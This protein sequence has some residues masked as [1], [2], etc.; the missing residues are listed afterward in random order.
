VHGKSFQSALSGH[1][2]SFILEEGSMHC[3][4]CGAKVADG[5]SF[6]GS[7]GQP[8]VGYSVATTTAAPYAGSALG[9]TPAGVRAYAGFWLR[10]VAYLID[11]LVAMFVVAIVAALAIGFLG[12]EFFRAQIEEMGRG[13]NGPN[14]VFPVMLVV[15]IATF[16]AFLLIV[17]WIYFAGMESS[18]YQGT[19]GKMALGLVVTD[20]NGQRI[21]F[22]RAS[23]RFFSKLITGLVPFYIGYI[24]AGFT[25]K[26]QALHDM[27]AS[28]LVLRKA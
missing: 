12:V 10:F 26:K 22:A 20:M 15:T 19:L 13:M 1:G 2:A 14:P 16:V 3:S 9:A 7:C 6:C 4:K 5:V 21:S 24:M 25:E 18:E 23:G 8:I 11:S 27:I 28:C 17:S